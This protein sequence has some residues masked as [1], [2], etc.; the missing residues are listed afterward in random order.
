M[1]KKF[2]KIIVALV[3]IS[4]LKNGLEA[5][6]PSMSA[7]CHPRPPQS[8]KFQN[9][10]DGQKLKRSPVVPPQSKGPQAVISVQNF[11]LFK[12]LFFGNLILKDIS[13]GKYYQNYYYR[14]GTKCSEDIETEIYWHRDSKF[15]VY[16][17]FNSKEKSF[18]GEGVCLLFYDKTAVECPVKDSMKYD[19]IAVRLPNKIDFNFKQGDFSREDDENIEKFVNN[20]ITSRAGYGCFVDS[21]WMIFFSMDFC[22]KH[23]DYISAENFKESLNKLIDMLYDKGY[24]SLS[25]KIFHEYVK[26][27]K[28]LG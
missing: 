21:E 24:D 10:V 8:R 7:R 3:V 16:S 5:V 2:V 12:I 14:K 9:V 4:S 27:K 18:E 22:K 17:F 13:S 15:N 20:H 23:P 1:L 19:I 26:Q 25:S 28:K 6:C 11:Q